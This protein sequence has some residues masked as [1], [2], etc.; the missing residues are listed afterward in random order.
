M[1]RI[2]ELLFELMREHE[3][4]RRMHAAAKRRQDAHADVAELVAKALDRDRAIGR[5]AARLRALIAE[6]ANQVA[7]R[8]RIELVLAFEPR[9]ARRPASATSLASSSR[10]NAPSA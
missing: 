8:I 6:V 7:G 1:N 2:A 5:H 3:R 4:P 9:A 10:Q